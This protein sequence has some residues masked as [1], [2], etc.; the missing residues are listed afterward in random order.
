MRKRIKKSRKKIK[1]DKSN[2]LKVEF[3]RKH[4]YDLN[5]ASPRTLSEK[6]QWVKIFGNLKRFSKY[7]DKYEVRQY[8]KEKVGEQY[9]IPLI[10]VY[11]MVE[12]KLKWVVCPIHLH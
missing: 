10:G 1:I 4:G 9:L 3:K 11:N 5:L 7:V 6:I 12:I 2:R 8:V